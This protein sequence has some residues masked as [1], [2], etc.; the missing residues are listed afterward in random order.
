MLDELALSP[1]EAAYIGANVYFTLEGWEANYKFREMYGNKAQGAPK[2]RPGL[3]P[4]DVVRK[5]VT[6]SGPASLAKTNLN[7]GKVINS[8]AASSGSNLLGRTKSGF[9]YILQ[10]ERSGKKHLVIAVRGTR[11]EMGYPDLITDANISS[12]RNMPGIGPVH[13]GFY[14][15]YKTV[16]PTLNAAREVVDAA[17][18]IHCV[19]HSL[20]G[21]VANLIALHFARKGVKTR[22]YTFGAPRVGLRAAQYDQLANLYIG[23]KNIYRV[24][25]NFDPI[26]MIPVAP[27]I[28]ALPSIKDKNN[29]FIGSPVQAID[30]QNHDTGNYISSVG[31]KDWNTLRSDKLKQG[32]LD[33]QYFVS[34]RSSESWL[35][36]YLGHSINAGMAILQ[37][38]LQ[39]LIDT[40][41]IGF[42]EIATI[43]DLLAVAI[44][45]GIN[46]FKVAKNHI[47]KFIADCARMFGMG[48]EVSKTVLSKLFR[49]LMTE[50]AITAKMAM[51]KAVKI[52]KSK[53][54]KV[55]LS[56]ATAG[57]IGLLLI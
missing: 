51:I 10:F 30:I 13:A 16:L 4:A 17:D 56:T 57:S 11:P 27:Y 8:F 33:K 28:H 5:N 15:V 34:W 29:I 36:Q 7:N 50:L 38:V 41:G 46:I 26:P 35:K 24:S 18:V 12:N 39:G 48:V 53:E 9:G 2:P 44:R 31:V 37:R 49:K 45:D 40:V 47:S 43:L 25:H 6:G 21:A 54:F 23:E 1:K 19:G 20:G 14:D 42:S 55:V 3:A 52:A 32:Y 22:L